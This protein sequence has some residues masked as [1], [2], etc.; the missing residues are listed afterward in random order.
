MTEEEAQSK[1]KNIIPILRESWERAWADIQGRFFE[2]EHDLR[3][4]SVILQM[5]AVIYAK[6]LLVH[7]QRIHYHSRHTQHIFKIPGT[8]YIVMKQLR[9]SLIPNFNRTKH[10]THFY[11][12]GILK[13]LE[14]HPRLICGLVPNQDWTEIGGIFLTFPN[15]EGLANNWEL[16]ISA[17]VEPV[18]VAQTRIDIEDGDSPLKKPLFTPRHAQAAK[19]P[20][21]K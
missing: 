14:D 11:S 13:G 10:A 15:R 6:N 2:P 21:A 17:G 9:P 19:F 3:C 8:A 12:Q 5:Q 20:T 18:D 1:L 4:R 7:D 16:N